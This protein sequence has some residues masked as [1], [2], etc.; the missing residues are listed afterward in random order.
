[1]QITHYIK[2]TD[3]TGDVNMFTENNFETAE[4]KVN[5]LGL[6]RVKLT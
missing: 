6:N 3:Q 2:T 1:M 4:G 5:P